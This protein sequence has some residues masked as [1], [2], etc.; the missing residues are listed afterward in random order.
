MQLQL[1]VSAVGPTVCN[2]GHGGSNIIEQ[3]LLKIWEHHSLHTLHQG[4]KRGSTDVQ[5]SLVTEHFAYLAK[6]NIKY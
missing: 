4:F 1:D 5:S 6:L 3:K 2:S